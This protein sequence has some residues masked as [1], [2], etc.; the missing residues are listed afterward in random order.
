MATWQIFSM[1]AGNEALVAF[2]FT[3]YNIL[4]FKKLI[5][6]FYLILIEYFTTLSRLLPF[7]IYCSHLLC[8]KIVPKT[9]SSCYLYLCYFYSW[10][11]FFSLKSIILAFTTSKLDYCSFLFPSLRLDHENLLH[12]RIRLFKSELPSY[13]AVWGTD[14]QQFRSILKIVQKSFHTEEVDLHPYR[15][16]I[17][18]KKFKTEITETKNWERHKEGEDLLRNSKGI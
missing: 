3:P 14:W 9:L 12:L 17:C 5:S 16:C 4:F 15:G 6:S 11:N 18:G 8:I 2:I 7:K 1:F 10:F 13:M